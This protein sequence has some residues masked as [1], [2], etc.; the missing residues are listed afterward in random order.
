M[1]YRMLRTLHLLCC[2]PPN[3]IRPPPSSEVK[4]HPEGIQ[5]LSNSQVGDFQPPVPHTSPECC[6]SSSRNK[7]FLMNCRA[8]LRNPPIRY[9]DMAKTTSFQSSGFLGMP[10]SVAPLTQKHLSPFYSSER[11]LVNLV[12]LRG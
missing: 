3:A 4:Q 10:A 5:S 8:L 12:K 1:V 2:L 11:R 9:V 6:N 7:L